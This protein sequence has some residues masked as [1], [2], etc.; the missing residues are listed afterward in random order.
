M[1]STRQRGTTAPLADRRVCCASI[2]D[3]PLSEDDAS[4][5]ARLLA[6]VADPVRLRI[7]SLLI[8]NEEICSCDLEGPLDRSQPTVSHH[9]RILSDAGLISGQKRGKWT[10]WRL[11]HARLSEI[12]AALGG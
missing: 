2:T 11:D 4:D 1:A 12:R 8:A 9:T 7:L 5:L 10:W 6:A 3:T